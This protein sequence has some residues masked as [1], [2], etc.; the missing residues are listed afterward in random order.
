MKL[1]SQLF[2]VFS[3]TLICLGVWNII[4]FNYNP[5]SSDNFI[6][7]IFFTS[8][9]VL[10]VG[11]LT[12]IF[13]YLKTWRSNHEIIYAHLPVSLRQAILISLIITGLIVLQT[14]RVLTLIDSLMF[15]S[16]ILLIELFFR[17]KT[18]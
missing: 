4:L 12:F 8:L 1:K 11:L 2:I 6:I 15:I 3:L 5:Y 16:L 10:L 17:T 18:I 9:F 14:M 7:S 13:F